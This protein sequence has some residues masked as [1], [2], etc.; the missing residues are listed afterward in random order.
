VA[1]HGCITEQIRKV[2]KTSPETTV[3]PALAGAWG[4]EYRDH[5]P[6]ETQIEALRKATPEVNSISHFSY[7]WQEPDLDRRR[8]SCKLF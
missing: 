4:K 7:A 8:Q 3:I 1:S 6:L 2:L 5:L